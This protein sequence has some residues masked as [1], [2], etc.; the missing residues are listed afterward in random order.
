MKINCCKQYI[1]CK[2]QN[3]VGANKVSLHAIKAS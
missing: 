3:K 2:L 1:T